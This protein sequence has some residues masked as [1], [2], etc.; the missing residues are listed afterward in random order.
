[1]SRYKNRVARFRDS[2][3]SGCPIL[4]L[5]EIG[6]PDSAPLSVSLKVYAA[7]EFWVG[8]RLV[9]EHKMCVTEGTNVFEEGNRLFRVKVCRNIGEDSFHIALRFQL[10]QDDI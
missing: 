3:K 4:G 10:E 9:D 1:M 2:G 8:C 5:E 7:S 6:L